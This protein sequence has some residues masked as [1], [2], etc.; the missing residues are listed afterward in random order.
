MIKLEDIK[1]C[2]SYISASH[3]NE[4]LDDLFITTDS[5]LTNEM[6]T[7]IAIKGK[8][9]N[10]NSFIDSVI[11]NGIKI[12][13]AAMSDEEYKKYNDNNPFVLFIRILDINAFL[14][15][16]AEVV[17]LKWQIMGGIVIGVT[18]SNGKTTNKE[19]LYSLLNA[20]EPEK[21]HKTYGNFNN[22][23]GVPLTIFSL[24]CW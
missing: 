12:I 20:I 7:F 4:F 3:Q 17:S 18:G 11:D 21:V 15:E 23:I 6:N 16:L 22:H 2:S 1:K 19:M 14:L 13:I 10:A 24:T 5:R 8:N 9:F